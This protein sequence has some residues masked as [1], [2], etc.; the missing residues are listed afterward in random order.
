MQQTHD[1]PPDDPRSRRIG[2]AII[3][4]GL[5]LSLIFALMWF[6]TSGHTP[7]DI[8]PLKKIAPPP[9]MAQ[10]A[11]IAASANVPLTVA[12]TTEIF[13]EET[14]DAGEGRV[15]VEK[16][17]AGTVKLVS[18]PDANVFFQDRDL[19]LT[20]VTAT[21]AAGKQQLRFENKKL[22]LNKTVTLTVP[23]NQR[24]SEL[25]EF[26][27][28][29]LDVQGPDG[30]RVTVDGVARGTTPFN[31]VQVYEGRHRIDTVLASGER[32]SQSVETYAGQTV[33][34]Y[35]TR[36]DPREK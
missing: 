30:T 22:G 8:S 6:F 2:V 23:P 25:F 11:P 10:K 21:F 4:G 24:T 32:H 7:V 28:G 17:V 15:R 1:A 26:F 19:G 12:P 13:V 35:V 29:W 5:F 18:N 16:R 9:G 34:H 36:P 14:V 27:T 20:P 31:S 33:T 3:G